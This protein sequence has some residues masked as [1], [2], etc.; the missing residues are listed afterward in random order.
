M[1]L[2]FE[3][4]YS[5]LIM[6]PKIPRFRVVQ[7]ASKNLAFDIFHWRWGVDSRR[8]PEPPEGRSLRGGPVSRPR[9]PTGV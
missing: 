1:F 3:S 5:A 4:I 7:C 6:L 9:D 2:T 8:G